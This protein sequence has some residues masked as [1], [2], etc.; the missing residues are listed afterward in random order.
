M[1]KQSAPLYAVNIPTGESLQLS[2]IEYDDVFG[3][4]LV[5]KWYFFFLE[6]AMTIYIINICAACTACTTYFDMSL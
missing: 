2:H 1:N 4:N 5:T 3:T 6:H